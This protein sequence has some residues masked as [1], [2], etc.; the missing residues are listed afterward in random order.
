MQFAG[1]ANTPFTESNGQFSPDG[2]L[3]AYETNESGRFEIVV[4]TF[5]E[6]GGKR[7]FEITYP[8]L[9]QRRAFFFGRDEQSIPQQGARLDRSVRIGDKK[10]GRVYEHNVCVIL[11]RA[12]L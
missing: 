12:R 5:P 11:A 10:F 2:R 7:Q 9:I 3:V 8:V 6:P 4:Q 1:V